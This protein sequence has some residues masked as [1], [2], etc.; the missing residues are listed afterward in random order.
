MEGVCLGELFDGPLRLVLQGMHPAVGADDGLDQALAN[1]K[2]A[3]RQF[4]FF[5]VL[6]RRAQRLPLMPESNPE[7]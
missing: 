5:S 7:M 4:S 6:P 3:A 1:L 2:N